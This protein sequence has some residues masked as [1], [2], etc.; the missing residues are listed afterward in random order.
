MLAYP[1]TFTGPCPRILWALLLL[2][3]SLNAHNQNWDNPRCT[4][5]VS[6]P[7]GNCVEMACNISNTF[8]DI[9]IE[10]TANGKTTT[11]FNKKPPG[12]YSN[13]SWQLQIQGGQAQLVITDAQDIHAGSYLWQLNGRQRRNMYLILNVTEL[14]TANQDPESLEVS[15]EPPSAVS[16]EVGII[17]VGVF[18]I[19]III[20]ISE[21]A[22]YKHSH[23]LRCHRF[24]VPGPSKVSWYPLPDTA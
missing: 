20:G 14:A 6:A 8:R 2:V 12:N 7:R 22:W 18:S 1:I 23:L 9:T 3:V 24:V 4:E 5:V 15:A 17:V 16:K 19:I 11:I 10:L 21:F 13:D